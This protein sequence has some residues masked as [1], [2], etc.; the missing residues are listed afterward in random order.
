MPPS[1]PPFMSHLFFLAFLPIFTSHLHFPPSLPSFTSYPFFPPSIPNFTFHFHFPPSLSTFAAHLHFPLSLPTLTSYL[2]FPSSLPSFIS[3]FHFPPSLP[4]F[5]SPHYLQAS[6]PTFTSHFH[7]SSSLPSRLPTFHPPLPCLL[8]LSTFPSLLHFT[9]MLLTFTPTFISYIHLSISLSNSKLL[10]HV[11]YK[12]AAYLKQS[13]KYCSSVLAHDTL[14]LLLLILKE[15]H[16]RDFHSLFL[17]FF[18]IFQSLIYTKFCTANIFENLRQIRMDIRNFPSLHVFAEVRT[19][20]ECSHLKR[21]VKFSVV[22]VTAH[23]RII[24]SI[25]GKKVESN[26]AFPTTVPS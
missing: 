24:L 23:F 16:A 12:F 11:L 7:L 9:P 1:L 13:L 3:H 22:F 4:I 20:S 5:I 18:C 2:H 17:T 6:I 21:G 10:N 25:C 8:S 14:F 19:I 15:T 26:S